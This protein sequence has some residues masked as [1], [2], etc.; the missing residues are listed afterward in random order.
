MR[1]N[2]GG[3]R[4]KSAMRYPKSRG[5]TFGSGNICHRCGCESKS[6][7]YP[8][9]ANREATHMAHQP[10]LI[11]DVGLHKGEDTDFYLKKGF[12]V[13]AFEA[14]PDLIAHCKVRFQEPIASQRLRIVEGAIAP[15]AAGERIAFYRNLQD[16]GWGTIVPKW[17]ERKERQGTRSV[18]MQVA[19][20][21]LAEMFRTYGIP[22]YLKIDI[23]RADHL[24]LDELRRFEDRPRYISMEAEVVDFSQLVA[25][26][27]SLND[28]GYTTFKAVQQARIPGTAIATTTLRGEPLRHIFADYASGPFGEDL[29][30]PWLSHGECLRRFQTIFRL[31]RLF[32][33]DG[34]VRN[35]PGG[36]HIMRVL[37]RLYRKPLPGWYDIHASLR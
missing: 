26:L 31:Y 17:M 2:E 4:S 15:E 3:L 16:S 5:T 36:R 22:L 27:N 21:D 11:F 8:T 1:V 9:I 13:V 33:E 34:V 20:V 30:G 37:R 6:A 32:G 14:N 28:L 12:R 19:R 10:D 23:E 25:E 35:L 7:R 18:K 29:A 24:V